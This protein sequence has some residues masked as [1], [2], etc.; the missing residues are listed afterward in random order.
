MARLMKRYGQR[1]HVLPD[2]IEDYERLHAET[3]P[4]VLE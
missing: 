2:R 4:G 1:I 3:W